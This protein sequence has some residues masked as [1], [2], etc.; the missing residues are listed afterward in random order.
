MGAS[1][2]PE[3]PELL[4]EIQAAIDDLGGCVAP[5]FNW[6]A[7]HDAAWVSSNKSLACRN[8]DEVGAPFVAK[9]ASLCVFYYLC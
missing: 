8:A 1:Q 2:L 4:A 3:F 6:S 5:K 9:H 7:P